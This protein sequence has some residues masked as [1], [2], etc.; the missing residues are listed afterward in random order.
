MNYLDPADHPVWKQELHAGRADP[1][2]AARL[3]AVIAAIHAGTQGSAEIARRFANDATFHSIRIEPYLE[4]TARVHT[5]LAEPLLALAAETLAAK[6][7]LVHGDVS[8]KNILVGPHGPVILDAECAWHGEP[9]FDLAFCL[10]HLLLKC[11]WT[12]AASGDFLACFDALAES[13]LAGVDWEPRASIEARV[14]RLLPALFLARVDGK[15][16]AEYIGADADKDRIR[17]VA[18]PL[19][20]TPAARLSTIRQL[21]SEEISR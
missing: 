17:R 18:R 8:P 11:L 15:S 16:P 9:A 2:F 7:A 13:Y 19:I 3:G 12:P 5:D 4:A 21:W 1:A 6:M 10:N 14:A 20:A